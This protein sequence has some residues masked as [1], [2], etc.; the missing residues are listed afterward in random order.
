MTLR[1]HCK[2]TI[3]RYKL[4]VSNVCVHDRV[5]VFLMYVVT[6]HIDQGYICNQ[7][8]SQHWQALCSAIMVH[9]KQ[10]ICATQVLDEL[11]KQYNWFHFSLL[12]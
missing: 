5:C 1:I 10:Q 6:L 12:W 2:E 8:I 4:T 11:L 7:N 3:Y 9:R